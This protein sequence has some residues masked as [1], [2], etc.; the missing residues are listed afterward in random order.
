MD[1]VFIPLHIHGNHWTLLV[2]FFTE[3]TI[4]YFDSYLRAA[5]PNEGRYYIG[6]VR[7]YLLEEFAV[8]YPDQ[9]HFNFDGWEFVISS[10]ANTPQQPDNYNCGVFVLKLTELIADGVDISNTSLGSNDE[11]IR[12]LVNFRTDISKAISEGTLSHAVS[13]PK[14]R[15]H[16]EDKAMAKKPKYQDIQQPAS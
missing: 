12:N 15:K 3:K 10:H 2:I 11:L 5:M 7:S 1:K 14:K 9:N 4:R 8:K 6:C 13:A 16:R